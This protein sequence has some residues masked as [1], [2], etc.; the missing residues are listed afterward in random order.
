MINHR[1]IDRVS[2][3]ALVTCQPAAVI[4]AAQS[5]SGRYPNL[6][7]GILMEAGVPLID[8]VGEGVMGAVTEGQ[9]ATV[10]GDALVVA[11]QTVAQGTLLDTE[12]VAA[13]M[14]EARPRMFRGEVFVPPPPPYQPAPRYEEIVHSGSGSE[15]G[16]VPSTARTHSRSDS[17]HSDASSREDAGEGEA[18]R[19]GSRPSSDSEAEAD[20]H[21]PP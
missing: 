2:A 5:I 8:A 17:G 16:S 12:A 7:P 10:E 4:N 14:E 9:H 15:S 13:A 1:D 3:E 20:R 19:P 6:G 21:R 11:G 18:L